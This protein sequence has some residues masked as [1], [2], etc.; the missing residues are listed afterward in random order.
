VSS[1]EV[2]TNKEIGDLLVPLT[3]ELLNIIN[4]SRYRIDDVRYL[5][6]SNLRNL[7]ATDIMIFNIFSAMEEGRIPYDSLN[8]L[9]GMHGGK[10]EDAIVR[11]GMHLRLS[12]VT[13][14]QF[15]VE[16]L[17]SNI[18]LAL[19]STALTRRGY[20]QYLREL[21]SRI[22][23]SSKPNKIAILLVLQHMRNSLHA[24][25]IH[26]NAS[27]HTEINGRRYEFEKGRLV[28]CASWPAITFAMMEQIRILEEIV[29]TAEISRITRTI[30]SQFVEPTP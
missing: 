20:A 21:I 27:F 11:M 10:P 29:G 9:L 14:F 25:G 12:L 3:E 2:K 6:F 17:I 30:S 8:D 15:Q 7:I 19:D 28:N 13:L 22:T 18:L 26:N 1:P 4:R 23:I 24:N 16:N 5:I